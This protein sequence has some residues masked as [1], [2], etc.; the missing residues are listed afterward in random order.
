MSQTVTLQIEDLSRGGSGVARLDT[1]EGKQVVFVPGT[2]PGDRVLAIIVE[3][4]KRFSNAELVEVLSPSPDRVDAPCPVFGKCGGCAW[5]HIP[6]A[7]QWKTKRSGALHALQ[8]TG[9]TWAGTVDEFPAKNPWNY[10]NRIQM[11]GSEQGLGFFA[12]GSRELVAVTKCF[13]ARE[14]INQALPKIQTEAQALK[15]PYKVEIEVLESGEVRH[16]WNA[17][18]AALG[19]RQV[20][21]EQ[22]LNL[23]HYVSQNIDSQVHLFDLFGGAGNLSWD[24]A[25]RMKHI[26]CVD[27]G[28]PL[29]S[30]ANRPDNYRFFKTDVQKW[31]ER[32]AHQKTKGTYPYTGPFE[33]ILDPPREGL[34]TGFE[35]ISNSFETLGVKKIIAVGCDP[36]SWARDV[37]RFIKKGYRLEKVAVFDLFPQT[38]HVEAVGVL[39]RNSF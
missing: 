17:R 8:R 33:V 29:G 4:A 15:P 30:D 2:L 21:D 23:R 39:I 11:R 37:S 27:V 18:H 5:Q 36:D 9:I 12:R 31:I 13:I 3:Q 10:R 24:L 7:M 26:D 19:F 16:V 22:N 34:A 14:E 35:K 38:P 28:S 32:Q 20:N 1:P 25:S 6:Y